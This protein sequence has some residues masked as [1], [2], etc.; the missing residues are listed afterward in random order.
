MKLD[1]KIVL[2]LFGALMLVSSAYGQDAVSQMSVEDK[3]RIIKSMLDS[4]K[5]IRRALLKI[6]RQIMGD[7]EGAGGQQ[8]GDEDDDDDDDNADDG[9]DG[10]DISGGEEEWKEEQRKIREAREQLEAYVKKI[11]SSF[12]A[13]HDIIEKIN[14][15]IDEEIRE[16]NSEVNYN[17]YY[18]PGKPFQPP[19]SPPF[20]SKQS[21]IQTFDQANSDGS[22]HY[23]RNNKR[24]YRHTQRG[25]RALDDTELTVDTEHSSSPDHLSV[26]SS[27]DT[28]QGAVPLELNQQKVV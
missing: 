28:L 21:A 22:S 4:Q 20:K 3:R 24:P 5:D 1:A 19:T 18:R 15:K 25:S 23:K 27:D 11:A 13:M 14:N 12:I 10:D 17:L 16:G 6:R 7:S 8:P 9:L 26:T 2:L